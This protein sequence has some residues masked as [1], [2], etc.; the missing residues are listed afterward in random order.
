MDERA[1]QSAGAGPGADLIAA[2]PGPAVAAAQGQAVGAG[3][4]GLDVLPPISAVVEL[5][6]IVATFLLVDWLWP[7]LDINNLQ[8]SVYWLPVL[9]LTLQYGT[10]SGSIA[11]VVAIAATF[12]LSTMPEQGVGENEFTYRLRI[13]AQPILWIGTAV[14]LGQ[15]R[16]LQIAAKSELSERVAE[17]EAQGRTL[18]DYATRLRGRCDALER[19]IVA[20][21]PADGAGILNALAVLR[22]GTGPQE[23]AISQC[24][25]ACAPGGTASLYA[26]T[27]VGLQRVLSAGWPDGAS[28][29]EVIP[30]GHPLF[31]ALVDGRR[32]LSVLAA[33]D[34]AALAKQGLVAVPV[35][36]LASGRVSGMIKIELASSQALTPAVTETLAFLAATVAPRLGELLRLA[37][38]PGTDENSS[39][40]SSAT[41]I[42]LRPPLE[43]VEV[44]AGQPRLAQDGGTGRDAIALRPKVGP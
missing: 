28:W 6:A 14:L 43:K 34:E 20:R 3:A 26:R 2:E 13:L 11:A 23:G 8:P 42:P 24:L 29:L 39:S 38:E 44:Q 21:P 18:A 37:L 15:F 27:P 19:E 5:A 1:A 4:D 25:A 30:Q 36:D 12:A 10:V 32:S 7:T 31:S 35:I 22:S 17:L 16:M 9:L 40:R 33:A 41:P